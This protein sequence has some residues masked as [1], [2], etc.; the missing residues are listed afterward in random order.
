MVYVFPLFFALIVSAVAES[1]VR[2]GWVVPYAWLPLLAAPPLLIRAARGLRRTG[3][4]RAS[5]LV[6]NLLAWSPWL[7]QA[8]AVCVFGYGLWL[9]GQG[10]DV[11]LLEEWPG[12]GILLLLVPYF[13]LEY[14]VLEARTRS[15]ETGASRRRALRNFQLRQLASSSGQLVLILL[16]T[17]VSYTHLTLPTICSV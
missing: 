11:L 12:L 9:T 8:I 15:Y 4:M 17:P 14:A 1:G 13:A 2:A 3:R 7:G 10:V 5:A 16:F 6:E